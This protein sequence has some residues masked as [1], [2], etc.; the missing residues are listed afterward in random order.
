MA[1]ACYGPY[2]SRIVIDIIVSSWL[3]Q[4]LFSFASREYRC[5]ETLILAGHFLGEAG[6][7]HT[8]IGAAGET[9]TGAVGAERKLDRDLRCR[10]Y[11][12]SVF[13]SNL[14]YWIARSL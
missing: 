3:P 1:P 11:L 6:W 4:S 5:K 10:Y 12:G 13:G 7:G 8:R 14:Y 2:A 9:E